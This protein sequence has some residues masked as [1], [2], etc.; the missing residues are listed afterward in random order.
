[1]EQNSTAAFQEGPLS[2][3]PSVQAK[4]SRVGTRDYLG[5]DGT[6][7]RASTIGVDLKK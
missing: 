4:W 2:Y 7:Y 1:M 5:K 6:A 3:L